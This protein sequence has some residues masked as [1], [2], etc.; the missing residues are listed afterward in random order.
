MYL[1]VPLP[2]AS[3]RQVQVTYVGRSS[4]SQTTTM[5]LEM[6]Q[7]DNVG[8]LKSKVAEILS[9]PT[10]YGCPDEEKLQLIEVL[11]HHISR[12]VDDWTMLK[13]LKDDRQIY[14]ISVLSL[15]LTPA[16]AAGA[17]GDASTE[18]LLDIFPPSRETTTLH[19]SMSFTP[20]FVHKIFPM[21][22]CVSETFFAALLLFSL[23]KMLND[24]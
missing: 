16:Q 15:N 18:K 10:A 23:L 12:V 9:I 11:D 22:P 19:H 4:Q 3:I 14:V 6:S 8:H 7:S 13:C 17:A 21:N 1:P 24:C 20:L 5:L 2:N